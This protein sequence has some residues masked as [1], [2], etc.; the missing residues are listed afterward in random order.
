MV[1]RTDAEEQSSHD[2]SH[3]IRL[4]TQQD[5]VV[6][7]ALSFETGLSDDEDAS[8]LEP[9][10]DDHTWIVLEDEANTVIG[11]ACCRRCRADTGASNSSKLARGDPLA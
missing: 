11:A 6:V 10:D 1:S 8:V 7:H 3:T 2:T 4:A 9:F 5:A